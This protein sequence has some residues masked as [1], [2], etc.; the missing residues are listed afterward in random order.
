MNACVIDTGRNL[1][2]S[3]LAP[4]ANFP[5][6][7][8]CINRDIRKRCDRWCIRHQIF[9]ANIFD[10]FGNI[11][12]LY[13]KKPEVKNHELIPLK[14]RAAYYNTEQ[15]IDLFYQRL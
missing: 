4:V 12:W 11:K 3:S 14:V 8:N 1:P 7:G 5:V 15:E 9:V 13:L 2:L 10:I 6:T